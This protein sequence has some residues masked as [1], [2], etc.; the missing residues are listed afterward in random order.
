MVLDSYPYYK[1]S[2]LPIC[3]SQANYS[4]GSRNLFSFWTRSSVILRRALSPSKSIWVG[5]E[6]LFGELGRA[7]NRRV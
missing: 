3:L 7:F 5:P 1:P 2:L 6:E 4:L